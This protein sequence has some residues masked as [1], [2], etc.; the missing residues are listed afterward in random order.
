MAACQELVW[1]TA[2][3]LDSGVPLCADPPS[4][5]RGHGLHGLV[6]L[7]AS[8]QALPFVYVCTCACGYPVVLFS[9]STPDKHRNHPLHTYSVE[10]IT[11]Y[12]PLAPSDQY[13]LCLFFRRYSGLPLKILGILVRTS[14][15]SRDR[16]LK[17]HPPPVSPISS[18]HNNIRNHRYHSA[19]THRKRSQLPILLS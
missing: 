18:S 8:L 4:Y 11:E 2:F 10:H 13:Q 15:S 6:R 16:C 3:P 7:P 19:P 17:D 14:C 5:G 1:P 9:R 12:N